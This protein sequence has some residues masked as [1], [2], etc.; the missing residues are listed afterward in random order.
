MGWLP[1]E[2]SLSLEEG[3]HEGM[4]MALHV[5]EGVEMALHVHEGM[6][7]SLHVH[8][9]ME[10]SL[11][12]HEGVEMALHVH[13]GMEMALHVQLSGRNNAHTHT[14]H[15]GKLSLGHTQTHTLENCVSPSP[16]RAEE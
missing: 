2:S 7:M 12:V 1:L 3:I 13:E 6:E 10:M 16:P 15:M 5:H 14:H 11:H 9:G 8:E 4:E